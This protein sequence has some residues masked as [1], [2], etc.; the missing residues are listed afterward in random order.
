MKI[1]GRILMLLMIAFQAEN[2]FC[3]K[4]NASLP[5]TFM[6]SLAACSFQ[7][8]QILHSHDNRYMALSGVRNCSDKSYRE[9]MILKNGA[10]ITSSSTNTFLTESMAPVEIKWIGDKLY[11]FHPH[12]KKSLLKNELVM[13]SVVVVY[14][15]NKK[16][17]Y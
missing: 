13:D 5:E 7:I 1:T 11:I 14:P 4:R 17:F 12:V 8:E 9:V 10:W 3:Q 15:R 2:T 6:Q 16:S